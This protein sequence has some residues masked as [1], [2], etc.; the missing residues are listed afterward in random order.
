MRFWI[1]MRLATA[2]GESVKRHRLAGEM[3]PEDFSELC[4]KMIACLDECA[5]DFEFEQD[6][7]RVGL[8][9]DVAAE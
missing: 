7:E 2:G 9:A 1:D 6:R 4:A 3:H 8:G 5:P